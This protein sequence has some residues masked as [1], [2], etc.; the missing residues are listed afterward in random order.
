MT[1]KNCYKN[2]INKDKKAFQ[3]LKAIIKNNMV[4]VLKC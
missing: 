3:I 4:N 2:F 1:D